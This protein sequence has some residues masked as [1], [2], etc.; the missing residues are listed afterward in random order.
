MTALTAQ[1]SV[2]VRPLVDGDDASVRALFRRTLV[3][4]DP[5]PFDLPELGRYESL[6]LD[7]HLGPGRDDAA[8]A[9]SGGEVVGFALVCTDQAAY[10]RWVRRRAVVYGLRSALGLL[11]TAPRSPQARFH[12]SRLRDGL[13]IS[14]TPAPMPAHAHI[15]LAATHRAGWTGRLLAD[16]VDR[17]CRAAGLPGWFGEMNAVSGR[18]AAGLERLGGQVTHRAPNHTLSWLL[19][20]PVDRLTVARLLPGTTD[21]PQVP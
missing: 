20:R 12:R 1:T 2:T 3:M 17:R 13:V 14:R 16:H 6:C 7:W 8:V 9:V 15:N 19:G 5:L 21:V 4:G 18:R 11:R 10:R